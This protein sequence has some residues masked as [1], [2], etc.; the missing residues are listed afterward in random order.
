M[1]FNSPQITRLIEKHSASPEYD[2]PSVVHLATFEKLAGERQYLESLFLE[3]PEQK[4]KHLL[5]RFASINRSQFWGAWFEL[6][7]YGWLKKLGRIDFEM[8][9]GDPDFVLHSTH[10]IAIE[11]RA[12]LTPENEWL[13][14]KLL[15]RVFVLVRQIEL[16]YVIDVLECSA[17]QKTF[18][19]T[20]RFL[21]EITR[22]LELNPNE[23]YSYDDK[24]NNHLKLSARYN[25]N[26]TRLYCGRVSAL[27]RDLTALRNALSKKS[28]QHKILRIS[29]TPYVI[30][31]FLQSS[32]LSVHEVV[33]AWLGETVAYYDKAAG[34]LI[35]TNDTSGI[36]YFGTEIL[37]TSV[38]GTLVFRSSEN[39]DRLCRE[40]KVYWVENPF[41]NDLI[42][43]DDSIFPAENKLI[44]KNKNLSNVSMEWTN[45]I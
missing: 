25:P 7:L 42:K 2:I 13:A 28:T 4:Q 35:T 32:S 34:K 11:A 19:E 39:L 8:Q 40:L 5:S 33:S 45:G 36:H 21:S 16:P 6:M 12:I 14:D 26:L 22:W 18:F 1:I 41:A 20:K 44:V 38:S 17:K 24:H 43:I 31:V 10:K 23:K 9:D 29:N 37:H 15:G 27:N 3:I 30:A